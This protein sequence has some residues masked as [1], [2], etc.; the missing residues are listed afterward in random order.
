MLKAYIVTKYASFDDLVKIDEGILLA[1][2][3]SFEKVLM[4]GRD[5]DFL[6]TN[7]PLNDPRGMTIISYEESIQELE[8]IEIGILSLQKKGFKE[9]DILLEESD[10]FEFNYA[11]LNIF[12]R[13]SLLRLYAKMK[14]KSLT[15]YEEGSYLINRNDAPYIRI[16][17]LS[18]MVKFSFD[19]VQSKVV[20]QVISQKKGPLFHRNYLEGRVAVLH[21]KK[22]IVTFVQAKEE[23]YD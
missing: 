1:F 3:E 19:H 2:D 4:L 10:N 13:H 11:I 20:Q 21:I 8:K 6:V 22:G 14:K 17:P 7:N 12:K 9:I 5:P 15:I 18:E 16:Y 23:S